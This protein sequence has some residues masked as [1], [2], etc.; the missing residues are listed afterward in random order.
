MNPKLI[1]N[2]YR[3]FTETPK[4][5]TTGLQTICSQFH[6]AQHSLLKQFVIF[7]LEISPVAG[8]IDL[9]AGQLTNYSSSIRLL[10]TDVFCFTP[11]ES[12]GCT[13][14]YSSSS[15]KRTSFEAFIF[16]LFACLSVKNN[17]VW[18]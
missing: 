5:I 6:F 15:K 17:L 7:E 2:N 1:I 13:M 16:R 14:F 11:G 4:K 3:R 18:V 10:F 12:N 8:V 9:P